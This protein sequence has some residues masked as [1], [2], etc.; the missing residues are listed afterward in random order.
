MHRKIRMLAAALAL[1]ATVAVGSVSAFAHEGFLVS[2]SDAGNLR[3]THSGIWLDFGSLADVF[4]FVGQ[5]E[6][7]RAPSP[8]EL[9]VEAGSLASVQ[10]P[11]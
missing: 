5:L 3:A 1:A 9:V 4:T 6:S 11:F 2:R 7:L 8:N 10:A